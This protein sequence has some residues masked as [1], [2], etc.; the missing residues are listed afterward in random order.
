MLSESIH[1]VS[2]ASENFFKLTVKEYPIEP[3]TWL[4]IDKLLPEVMA[5]AAMTGLGRE[6]DSYKPSMTLKPEVEEVLYE[7]YNACRS[8]AES[9]P[10][11]YDD[12]TF[13]IVTSDMLTITLIRLQD[14]L[15]KVKL[16]RTPFVKSIRKVRTDI[17]WD[18]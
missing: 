16:N 7:Y 9:T 14:S 8:Y 3:M 2:D 12:G 15:K 17:E 10:F 6:M 1:L 11:D 5:H 4:Y 18:S 13:N